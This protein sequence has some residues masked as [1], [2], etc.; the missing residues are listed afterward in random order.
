MRIRVRFLRRKRDIHHNLIRSVSLLRINY[1]QGEILGAYSSFCT[2]AASS[3][4]GCR[5][6]CDTFPIP[7]T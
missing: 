6:K 3:R 1:Y 4:A 2:R 5:S 7:T